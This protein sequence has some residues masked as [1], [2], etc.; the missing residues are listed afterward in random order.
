MCCNATT[1]KVTANK[2]GHLDLMKRVLS[3]VF[4]IKLG[5]VGIIYILD[6]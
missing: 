6:N 2:N 4:C 1:Y 5:E 3:H